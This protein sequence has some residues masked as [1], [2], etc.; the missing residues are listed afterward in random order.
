MNNSREN[1]TTIY[2]RRKKTG[3]ILK[4][5]ILGFKM[6]QDTDV[7]LEQIVSRISGH[8]FT[9]TDTTCS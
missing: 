7:T 1:Q 4:H 5:K 9:V 8:A 3:N 6:L 2:T